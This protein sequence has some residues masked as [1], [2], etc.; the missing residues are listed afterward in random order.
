[1]AISRE[2][3]RSIRHFAI[4]TGKRRRM[5]KFIFSLSAGERIIASETISTMAANFPDFFWR[6]IRNAKDSAQFEQSL[7][8]KQITHLMVRED[9]LAD[10]L[11]NNL[12][13]DQARLWNEFAASRL[14]LNFRERG[15][16]VYQL[17]G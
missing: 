13:A 14:Q 5:R 3:C 4:S 16:A 9:L 2:R 8:G 12:T 17:N 1:M 6:A 10:F 7:R 15:H 11:S